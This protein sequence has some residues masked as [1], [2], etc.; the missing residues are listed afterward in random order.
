MIVSWMTG[1]FGFVST[2]SA[3]VDEYEAVW[4]RAQQSAPK[5]CTAVVWSVGGI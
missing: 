3:L 4:K 2:S 5:L 1:N